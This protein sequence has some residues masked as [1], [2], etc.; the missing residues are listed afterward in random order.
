LAG[1]AGHKAGLLHAPLPQQDGAVGGAADV[2]VWMGVGKKVF[3]F[4]KL[5][6]KIIKTIKIK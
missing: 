4:K 3:K 1:H 5:K 2:Y 6:L